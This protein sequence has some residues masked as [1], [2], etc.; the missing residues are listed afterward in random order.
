MKNPCHKYK[1]FTEL[2]KQNN[3]GTRDYGIVEGMD[4]VKYEVEEISEKFQEFQSSQHLDSEL[5]KRSG[6]GVSLNIPDE[7]GV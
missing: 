4:K 3:I 7:G 2:M 5:K 1:D 6:L